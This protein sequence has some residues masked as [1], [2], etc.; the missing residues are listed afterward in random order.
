M[1]DERLSDE[2]IRD[3]YAQ[4]FRKGT[5]QDY[6]DAARGYWAPER[7]WQ[8]TVSYMASVHLWSLNIQMLTL[9]Y[10]MHMVRTLGICC[11]SDV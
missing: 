11:T 1:G 4:L 10:V 8:S 7:E 9:L 3:V 5:K 6:R 2:A